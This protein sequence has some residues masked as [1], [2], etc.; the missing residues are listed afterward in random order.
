MYVYMGAGYIY[1]CEHIHMLTLVQTETRTRMRMRPYSP[2]KLTILT[3]LLYCCLTSLLN[4]IVI[5]HESI[6]FLQVLLI[7]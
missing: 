7:R 4:K 3:L 1:I 5:H 6:G 2:T